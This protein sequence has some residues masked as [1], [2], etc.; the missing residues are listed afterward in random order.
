[1]LELDN[2]A[3][4]A[5]SSPAGLGIF[6]GCGG[7]GTAA[8]RNDSMRAGTHGCNPHGQDSKN[9]RLSFSGGT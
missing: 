7:Q 3:L 8:S 1:M 9:Q 2:T 5:C 4:E 6:T